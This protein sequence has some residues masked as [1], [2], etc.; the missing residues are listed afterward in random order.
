MT[1]TKKPKKIKSLPNEAEDIYITSEGKAAL[2]TLAKENKT[3]LYYSLKNI[4]NNYG[5]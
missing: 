3:L 5:Y 2:F 4:Q 1:L